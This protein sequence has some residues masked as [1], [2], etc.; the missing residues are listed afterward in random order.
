M[1]I[2][3]IDPG[4]ITTAVAVGDETSIE[5][6]YEVNSKDLSKKP[7]Y[8]F[9]IINNLDPDLV[10]APSGYGLPPI[11]L[12]RIESKSRLAALLKY[13]DDPGIEELRFI[14]F[15][16]NNID[17]L[18]MPVVGL[19]SVYNLI[20]VPE[21]RVYNRIDLGT[22]DKTALA[23]LAGVIY[24]GEDVEKLKKANIVVIELGAFTAGIAIANG[25]IIDGVGGSLF[26][27]GLV[28]RGGL[29]T[30]IAVSMKRRI[31][32]R[33]VFSGGLRDLCGTTDL[34]KIQ[35]ECFTAY[36][37]YIDDIAKTIAMLEVSIRRTSK[38]KSEIKIYLSGRGALP[39][40]I[41]SLKEYGFN[42]ID[43]LPSYY[44]KTHVKRSVEGA[45]LYGL[46][47]S[48][49]KNRDILNILGILRGFREIVYY[50]N[51]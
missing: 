18:Q 38:I 13:A 24:S 10:I 31:Y 28:S 16:L 29:D 22:S 35:K 47:W 2:L 34:E 42:E 27:I 45:L 9:E 7:E 12:R 14:S 46:L 32:K 51:L 23:I 43:I 19:P 21:Y 48:G 40:I 6:Y 1:R 49:V 17:S 33:D 37:R 44:G 20:T 4:T 11:D 3:A 39:M 36:N 41:E 5:F 30:E 26:P 50:K 25:E 8:L 15:F